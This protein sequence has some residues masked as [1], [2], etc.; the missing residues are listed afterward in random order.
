MAGALALL[1]STS[2]PDSA[3]DVS[4]LY[5]QVIAAGN[6]NWTDESGDGVQEPLLDVT[7]FGASFVAGGGGGTTPNDPPKASFTAACQDLSCTFD[8]AGSSDPD[9]D[10]LG[11]SWSFG[12]TTTGSGVS[13]SR[14]YG[15][16]GTYTVVLTVSDGNGGSDSAAQ[17]VTVSRGGSSGSQVV[18]TGET[19]GSG[20]DWTA[21]VTVTGG[22]TQGTW[23]TGDPAG[24]D[25]GAGECSFSLTVRKSVPSLT[26]TDATDSSLS[27]T[28]F[29]P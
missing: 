5:H 21:I 29:K 2:D 13:T 16:D 24:C 15:A 1:A 19:T 10:P 6:G 3:A 11:Y 28:V 9:G 4:G 18:L 25:P 26:Y 20:R 14:T 27:V 7:G 8:A 23:S 12:D 17:D 22:A